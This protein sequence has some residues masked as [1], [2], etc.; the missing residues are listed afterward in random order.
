MN[1]CK[2]YINMCKHYKGKRSSGRHYCHAFPHR[3]PDAISF[4][5]QLHTSIHP[6]Q[7]GEWVYERGTRTDIV[8]PFLSRRMEDPKLFGQ[9]N[10][11]STIRDIYR[12]SSDKEVK[13]WCRIAVR[14]AKN[15]YSALV[16]YKE[17]LA[18]RGVLVDHHRR[19]EWQLAKIEKEQ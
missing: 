7:R 9:D 19:Q 16:I 6:R 2:C 3:I 15:M 14:M 8:N 4:G 17:M 10:L 5:D 11:C 12:K 1:D 18:E 13:L